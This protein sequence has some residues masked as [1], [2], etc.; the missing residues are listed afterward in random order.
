M[1]QDSLLMSHDSWLTVEK[2]TLP[3][4]DLPF[5]N[6]GEFS[7]WLQISAT[8]R[9]KQWHLSTFYVKSV[10]QDKIEMLPIVYTNITIISTIRRIPSFTHS[11]TNICFKLDNL[12]FVSHTIQLY[13]LVMM[14]KWWMETLSNHNFLWLMQNIVSIVSVCYSIIIDQTK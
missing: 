11:V 12:I 2:F 1:T 6:N 14:K 10:S 3:K 9:L 4:E 7:N 8:I 5:L 13:N